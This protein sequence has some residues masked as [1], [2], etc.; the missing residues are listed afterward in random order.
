MLTL[1]GVGL[2]KDARQAHKTYMIK[3]RSYFMT[4]TKTQGY[5]LAIVPIL[6]GHQKQLLKSTTFVALFS[7]RL[8]VH[9]DGTFPFIN[10]CTYGL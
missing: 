1:G 7:N 8:R 2:T 6:T 5:Y 10:G 3:F 4:N 9:S